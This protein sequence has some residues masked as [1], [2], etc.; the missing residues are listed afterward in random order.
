[1]RV[2]T[3]LSYWVRQNEANFW[4]FEELLASQELWS[5]ES[6]SQLGTQTIQQVVSLRVS[7]SVM[8]PASQLASQSASQ[9]ANSQSANSQSLSQSASQPAI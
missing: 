4:T 2:I 7:H 6:V 3:T 5:M 9:S 8:Q 1:V